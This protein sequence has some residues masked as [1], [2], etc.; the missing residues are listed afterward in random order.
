MVPPSVSWLRSVLLMSI[1]VAGGAD[2]P[3]VGPPDPPEP[4]QAEA[5][6]PS[7]VRRPTIHVRRAGAT[8]LSLVV[9]P[10]RLLAAV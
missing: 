2:D 3:A 5:A 7:A 10:G 8:V 9:P 6:R 4:P 1:A